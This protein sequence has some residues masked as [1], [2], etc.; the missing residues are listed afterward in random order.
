MPIVRISTNVDDH[1]VW[2]AVAGE[3]TAVFGRLGIVPDHVCTLFDF[4]R[5]NAIY[6]G[7]TSFSEFAANSQFALVEVGLSRRRGLEVRTALV[8]GL[9]RAFTPVVDAKRVAIDFVPREVEDSYIGLVPMGRPR[10]ETAPSTPAGPM[11][12]QPRSAAGDGV[13][14]LRPPLIDDLRSVL[15]R[16]WGANVLTA[17]DDVA[18]TRLV[19]DDEEWDSLAKTQLAISLEIELG[20]NEGALDPGSEEVVRLFADDATLASVTKA[21]AAIAERCAS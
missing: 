10:S 16:I 12:V 20:L 8:E 6:T 11:P 18:L 15:A 13:T 1:E 9:V 7:G 3:I 2:A 21:V 19:P 17:A 5:P 14:R 4:V